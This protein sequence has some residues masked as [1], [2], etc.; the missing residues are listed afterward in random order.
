MSRGFEPLRTGTSIA[1]FDG[2]IA[3]ITVSFVGV[4]QM[5]EPACS[6]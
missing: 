1:W 5:R 2:A 6:Y 4:E 3:R